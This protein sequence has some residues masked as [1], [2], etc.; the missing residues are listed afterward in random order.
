[1][2]ESVW[3]ANLEALRLRYPAMARR[4]SLVTHTGVVSTVRA[5]SGDLVPALD[6][7]AGAVLLSSRYDPNREARRFAEAHRDM[8][9]IVLLGVDAGYRIRGLLNAGVS[10]L[11]LIPSNFEL[12]AGILALF[13]LR[14]LFADQRVTVYPGGEEEPVDEWLANH[15]F[16]ALDGDA[17]LVL[18]PPQS[19]H[20]DGEVGRTGRLV[21]DTL[22]RIGSDFATQARFGLAWVRNILLGVAQC[23]GVHRELPSSERCAVVAAGP[24]LDDHI[25]ELADGTYDLVVAVDTALPALLDRGVSVDVVVSIDA[26]AVTYHHVMRGVPTDCI[27]ASDIGSPH[28]LGEGRLLFASGHP[29]A[30]LLH[31]FGLEIPVWDTSGGSVTQTAMDLCARLGARE[32]HLFGADYSYLTGKPY[33]RGTYAYE[34]FSGRADR[35]S[36]LESQT[37]SFVM[38]RATR[39]QGR[40]ESSLLDEYRRR[41]QQWCRQARVGVI[42]HDESGMEHAAPL[43]SSPE[44][45][46]Y[47]LSRQAVRRALRRYEEV[48]ADLS[49]ASVPKP[50]EADRCPKDMR[51]VIMSLVPLAAYLRSR[52]V[53]GP[54]GSGALDQA[55]LLSAARRIT[56]RW[57]ARALSC[58]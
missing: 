20:D 28:L 19:R 58:L 51:P 5:R 46:E 45:S 40:Y 29:I 17:R 14:D 6:T 7:E 52:R 11:I 38:T 4:L 25:G 1:M 15:Y 23:A 33:A 47:R 22:E 41:L 3:S 35:L 18:L 31:G 32:I 8:D 50:F 48:L 13:D 27:V 26:Q 30:G 42:S 53:R 37:V 56:R 24:S 39:H 2:T 43:K 44:L 55:E 21:V 9:T 12:L 16:P 57:V 54:T 49:L 10:R 34:V 36:S